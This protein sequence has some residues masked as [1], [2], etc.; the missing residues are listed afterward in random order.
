MKLQKLRIKNFKSIVDLELV[1]PSPFSV[2]VGPNGAGKSNIFEALEYLSYS[3]DFGYLSDSIADRLFDL[4]NTVHFNF[5]KESQLIVFETDIFPI[6][7]LRGKAIDEQDPELKKYIERDSISSFEEI[8]RSSDFPFL[9]QFSRI[10]VSKS[11]LEKIK[12]IYDRHLSLS[13]GNLE[14][15]LHRILLTQKNGG[16]SEWLDLFLPEFESLEV[17][18]EPLSGN[19]AL[20]I[21]QKFIEKKF[22]RNFI[23]DGTLNILALLTAVYQSDEPQFLCIEEPE[24]GLNP[25]VIRELVNFFRQAC[26]EYGHYIWLNTHSQT[27]VSE[28]KEEEF[29]L[30]E[31]IEGATKVRQFKSGDFHG[32]RADEAWLTNV[33]GGGNPW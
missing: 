29:I 19:F 16:I 20:Q 11:D 14:K 21:K 30:V 17:I 7:R 9:N 18:S 27:L 24:N 15:V 23:S 2:F 25:Y 26:E 12:I 31:K 6:Y 1:N 3:Y 10:F 22:S 5:S 28:L 8:M 4:D 13:A 32:L 33:L